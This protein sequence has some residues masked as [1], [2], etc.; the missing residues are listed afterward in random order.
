MARS[1][2]ESRFRTALPPVLIKPLSAYMRLGNSASA[3]ARTAARAHLSFHPGWPSNASPIALATTASGEASACAAASCNSVSGYFGPISAFRACSD[4]ILTCDHSY[5]TVRIMSTSLS[6]EEMR[7]LLRRRVEAAGG[8]KACA[9]AIGVSPQYLGDC[10]KGRR[11][12]GK[13]IATPLG[14]EPLTIYVPMKDS[15]RK[16]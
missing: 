15:L 6:A 12:I 1:V 16:R 8:Q 9:A 3:R 11:D 7:E 13:S 5:A 10:L 2:V 14:Y 4:F